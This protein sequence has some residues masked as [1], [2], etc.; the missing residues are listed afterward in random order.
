M[1]III[2]DTVFKKKQAEREAARRFSIRSPESEN[3]QY[4]IL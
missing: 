4:V 2:L 1:F 3:L